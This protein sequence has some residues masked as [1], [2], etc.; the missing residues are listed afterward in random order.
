MQLA[1]AHLELVEGGDAGGE[2][3]DAIV[4]GEGEVGHVDQVQHALG[5]LG[6][7]PLDLLAAW[8]GLRRLV[9]VQDQLLQLP[10]RRNR[11]KVLDIQHAADALQTQHLC[12]R[13]RSED[14]H[15]NHRITER[16]VD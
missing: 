5:E 7:A 8:L 13:P 9:A 4:A 16:A 15:A 10:Q 11:L 12:A 3:G 6:Q 14:P 1:G 2:L